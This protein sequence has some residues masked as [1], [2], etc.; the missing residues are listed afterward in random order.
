MCIV[1]YH[2]PHTARLRLPLPPVHDPGYGW[3]V[4]FGEFLQWPEDTRVSDPSFVCDLKLWC[5]FNFERESA[6]Q[7]LATMR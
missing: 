4:M 5:Y 6:T 7:K 1:L 2:P 3:G